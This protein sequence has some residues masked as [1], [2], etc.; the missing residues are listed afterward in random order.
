MQ[1]H[2]YTGGAP[3]LV[4]LRRN[5]GGKRMQLNAF[6]GTPKNEKML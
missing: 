6:L 3:A 2:E 1:V 5:R 4:A